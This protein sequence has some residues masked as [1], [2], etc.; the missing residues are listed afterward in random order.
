MNEREWEEREETS[1]SMVPRMSSS[2]PNT[3]SLILKLK[4]VHL[5][6]VQLLTQSLIDS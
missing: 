4:P 5:Y 6:P 2:I 3:G 1:S